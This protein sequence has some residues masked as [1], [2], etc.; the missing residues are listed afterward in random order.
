MIGKDAAKEGIQ[1]RDEIET[2]KV[3]HSPWCCA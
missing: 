1:E 2:E 3:L